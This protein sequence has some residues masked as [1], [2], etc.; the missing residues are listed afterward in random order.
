MKRSSIVDH[1]AIGVRLATLRRI[2]SLQ[3]SWRTLWAP[4]EWRLGWWPSCR[5]GA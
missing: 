4:M 5:R 1:K 2:H 3:V